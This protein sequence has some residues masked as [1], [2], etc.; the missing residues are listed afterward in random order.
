MKNISK[1]LSAVLI[2]LFSV[3]LSAQSFDGYALYNLQ[4][5]NTAYLIDKNGD[6]AHSW[7][8]SD[9]CNY[10]VKLKENGNI[11]RGGVYSNNV[12]NGAAVG[13]MIQEID[14]NGDVVWEY[15]YSNSN[16]C[17]HHDFT[18]LPNGNV[19]FIAWEVKTAAEL[20]QAG[21]ANATSSKWPDHLVEIQPNGSSAQIV[22]EWH[23]W[24][25]MIQDYDPT[26]DNYG[27]VADHP[28]LLDINAIT[29]SGGGP[30]GSNGD[31]FH[32][33]GIDYNADLDQ[34][35]FSSR[36][37][38][39]FFVIDH[40]TTT[41]E[42]AS[43]A[44]GNSGKGG[45]FLYRWGNA[46]N[47]GGNGQLIP[48][49]VHDPRWIKEGRPN[50]GYIQFFNNSGGS[51]SSSVVDAINPPIAGVN[52][53]LTSNVYGPSSYDWRHECLASN[54][55]QSASDRMSNGNTFVSVS[56]QYMYEVDANDNV[57]WQYNASPTKAFRYEC[58][59]AG[60]VPLLGDDPCDLLALTE[61]TKANL[62]FYPNPS[63]DGLFTL[64]GID[65]SASDVAITV[66]NSLG[67]SV[68]FQ[69]NAD[70]INL[71]NAPNGIYLVTL[72][73]NGEES[74]TRKISLLR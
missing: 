44:G 37:G 31:W 53:T 27:V 46:S 16:H 4:N 50:A 45:D 55:G 22:W 47:Y 66:V 15:V 61:E 3:Q 7:S 70:V 23:Y 59:F 29:A 56:Q 38:S 18:L 74:V 21:R 36:Y 10:S 67:Q 64:E 1:L 58:D 41:A 43:H 8:C 63:N 60:L 62:K 13:G 49:A 25:H 17:S 68:D 2:V 14:P 30:G 9:P 51:G 33:N 39:E 48:A 54:S 42:A 34:L 73:F 65:I 71:I 6:I 32:T 24:D 35:V 20:T 11:V 19:I 5:Q 12:L 72:L 52:Y 28:E 26:K 57:V 40:S 69:R